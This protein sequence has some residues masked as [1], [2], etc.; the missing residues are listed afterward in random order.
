MSGFVT[1]AYDEQETEEQEVTDEFYDEAD[2]TTTVSDQPA[3]T[4]LAGDIFTPAVIEEMLGD[5]GADQNSPPQP[6]PPPTLAS[7]TTNSVS[8]ELLINISDRYETGKSVQETG[9]K[10][11]V[12]VRLEAQI[13]FMQEQL[14]AALSQVTMLEQKVNSQ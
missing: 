7:Q 14:N 10:T 6:G 11:P 3:D 4:N 13:N 12:E 9:R 1:G 8:S 5:W 2:M